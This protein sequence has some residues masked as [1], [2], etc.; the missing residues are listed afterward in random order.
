MKKT[1]LILICIALSY[2]MKAQETMKQKEAGLIFNSLNNFGL[3]YKTGTNKSLWR[4]NTLFIN[5]NERKH[6]LDTV[7]N[8]F[9][10][11]GFGLKIGKEFRKKIIPK[12][13][14]RY[15]VD[16][17]FAYSKYK[18]TQDDS[19]SKSV[20]Y[21]PGINLVFGLNYVIGENLVIGAELLPE[22]AYITGN[23]TNKNNGE[24]KKTDIKGFEYGLSNTSAMLT[25]AYRFNGL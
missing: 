11:L 25:I 24:E 2:T 18:N 9:S 6:T 3:T 16:L 15:G 21:K 22:F 20:T 19:E 1:L 13:E 12:F 5:G 7:E 4:F 17:S 23:I 14:L 10:T 8:V